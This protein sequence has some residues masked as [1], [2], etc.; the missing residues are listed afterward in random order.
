MIRIDITH[1][2]DTTGDR[3]ELSLIEIK[4]NIVGQDD[5]TVYAAFST[6][7][8]NPWALTTRLRGSTRDDI[9]RLLLTAAIE[10]RT[11]GHIRPVGFNLG[12]YPSARELEATR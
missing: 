8:E 11:N 9:L 2:D 6:S 12:H 5:G 10:L 7:D 4:D 3:R 1:I